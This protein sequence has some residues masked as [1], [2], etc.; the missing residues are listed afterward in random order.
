MLLLPVQLR[1][2]PARAHRRQRPLAALALRQPRPVL[3]PQLLL[4][5]PPP[6]ISHASRIWENSS[7][8]SGVHA[9]CKLASVYCHRW[10]LH[11]FI[12]LYTTS[13]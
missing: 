2:R 4:L 12:R 1:L 5:A 3:R 9:C 6:L 11:S 7:V 13:I 8:A 10:A